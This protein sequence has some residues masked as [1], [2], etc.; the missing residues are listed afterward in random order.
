MRI[1]SRWLGLPVLL[2]ILADVGFMG[3]SA[4]AV[5]NEVASDTE[6]NTVSPAEQPPVTEI[7]EEPPPEIDPTVLDRLRTEKWT[8][9]IDGLQERRYIRA[10]VLYSKTG[11]FYDGPQPRGISYEALKE[12]ERFLNKKLNT[13]KKP[14]YIVFIPVTH[15]EGI[16]RMKSGRGDIAAANIPIY[17][18]LRNFVEFSDPVRDKAKEIVVTGPG[19]PAV[20][21]LDDLA[22]KEIFVRK[23]SRYY[24]NLTSLNQKFAESGRPKM[25]LK[26]ADPNLE[27]ADILNMVAS[28]AVGM[29]VM[30]DIIAKLWAGVYDGLTLHENIEMAEVDKIGWAVQKDAPNLLALVN[31]FVKDHKEGTSFGNTLMLRYLKNTKWA[32]NNTGPSEMEK[33]RAAISL[34][35]KYG[36]EY[37]F[38]WLMIAAQAYQESTIDQSK[39]SPAGAFGVMQIKP[40]TAAGSPINIDEIVSNMDNNIH[41]GVKYLDYIMRDHFKDASFNKVNRAL[42]AFA[43]YNAGPARVAGLRRKAKAQGLD[44]NVWFN[45]VEIVAAQEIGAET[46]TYVSNIYKYYV[47]YK[48][49]AARKEGGT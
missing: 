41:A 34:F 19:A 18:E 35:K 7:A 8:G 25:I 30:D 42:F 15:Q 39:V 32:K 37:D 5:Q 4:P 47:A 11:F 44:E 13:G 1:L 29:T 48:L 6:T 33:F 17:P 43:A 14:I 3:C 10:L 45:N 36:A 24:R 27:D 49:V 2:L 20:S 23:V 40:S 31:E 22:G 26:E 28:G 38:D 12:F 21:S 9:D 46:V 16:D